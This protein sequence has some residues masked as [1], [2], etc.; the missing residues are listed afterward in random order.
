M[1][2]SCQKIASAFFWSDNCGRARSFLSSAACAFVLRMPIPRV[3]K[4]GVAQM[5]T[6]MAVRLGV[7]TDCDGQDGRRRAY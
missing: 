4:I 3:S 5:G 6:M 7:S 1:M 2:S